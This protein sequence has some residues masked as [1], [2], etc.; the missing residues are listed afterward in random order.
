MISVTNCHA[1]VTESSEVSAPIHLTYVSNSPDP[2]NLP[3]AKEIKINDSPEM[4]SSATS[5]AS[6]LS[7]SR[8]PIPRTNPNKMEC[9]Y[10]YA[11]EHG[12]DPEKFSIVTEAEKKRW[13]DKI[14]RGELEREIGLY[15]GA[16]ERKKD[17][18]KYYHYVFLTDRDRLIGEEIL[19]RVLLERHISSAW[20]DDL[21]KEWEKTY[22]QFIQIFA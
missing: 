22:T 13:A 6:V 1:H 21:M 18:R 10:Q 5:K 8:T 12:L 4:V 15:R 20:L 3:N 16:I 11:I 9:L 17:L 2:V 14:F 7:A 19:R